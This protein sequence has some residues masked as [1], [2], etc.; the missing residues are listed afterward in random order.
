MN[1]ILCIVGP[2]VN[3]NFLRISRKLTDKEKLPSNLNRLYLGAKYR[4][5]RF[6]ISGQMVFVNQLEGSYSDSSIFQLLEVTRL[7]LHKPLLTICK[8][9]V[10]S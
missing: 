7:I 8:I 6:F 4:L 1:Y 9:W 3:R 10:I 2:L 5:D